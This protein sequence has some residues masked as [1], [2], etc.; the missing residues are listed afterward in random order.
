M[1]KEII[2]SERVHKIYNE[3]SFGKTVISSMERRDELTKQL[4]GLENLNYDDL[5]QY[6]I[7]S[8]IDPH[9]KI[10]S[11]SIAS[12]GFLPS[13]N[14]TINIDP[15]I[16]LHANWGMFL[17]NFQNSKDSS[18]WK[19]VPFIN[20]F[21]HIDYIQPLL[22]RLHEINQTSETGFILS[23][24]L[25]NPKYDFHATNYNGPK[26][27]V[28]YKFEEPEYN[29]LDETKHNLKYDEEAVLKPLIS[30]EYSYRPALGKNIADIFTNECAYFTI[31]I[32]ELVGVQLNITNIITGHEDI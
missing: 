17:L 21:I 27:I 5:L 26:E 22:Q 2:L 13:I 7:E 14:Y 12:M 3:G 6:N 8:M 10:E 20:G 28:S 16:Q 1:S 15:Y 30:S 9:Y 18:R 32:N 25:D 29:R 23:Y 24:I 31:F 19:Y 4:N 11:E